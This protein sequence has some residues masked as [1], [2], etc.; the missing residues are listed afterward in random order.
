MENMSSRKRRKRSHP[1]ACAK[2][3]AKHKRTKEFCSA[4]VK[5]L[6]TNDKGSYYNQEM[7]L[8]ETKEESV[9]KNADNGGVVARCRKKKNG[10]YCEELW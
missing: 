8:E 7:W 3:M 10:E 6:A 4:W 5:K 9:D 2:K 1:F